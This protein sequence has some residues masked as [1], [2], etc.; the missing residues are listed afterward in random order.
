[1]LVLDD[2]S[3]RIAGRLLLDGASAR[4]PDGARVG[5]VGRN[6][7]GK[8]TLFRAIVGEIALEHGIIGHARARPHRT[9]RAG[10]ARR[11][12][13]PDRGRARGR[14]RSG[15][16][17]LPKPKPHTIRIA[18]PRSRPGLPTSVRT[19]HLRAP[20]QFSRASA[21]MRP[22]SSAPARIFPAAGACA[23]RSPPCC[24][25]SLICCCSTSQPTISISKARYG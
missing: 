14:H 4:I 9:A 21:S 5:L 24:S 7:I 15:P 12:G 22:R 6:G 3:V 1:M 18:S 13:E 8:T 17:C 19:R 20:P 16:A 23:S 11:A 10:G 2:I 25:P